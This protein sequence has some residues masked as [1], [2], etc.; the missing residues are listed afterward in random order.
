MPE[1]IGLPVT[2][3]SQV[4]DARRLATNLARNL[5][6]DETRRGRVA[7]IATELATNLVKHAQDGMLVLIP[8]DRAGVG[9]LELIAIDKGP[10]MF[11][12]ARCM[13]DGFSTAGSPGNGL[14]AVDRL[15]DDFDV[16]SKESGT[17][18]L[19]RLWSAA[20]PPGAILN[21]GAVCLPMLGEEVCGDAW[22]TSEHDGRASVLLV[23]GL[24]HGPQAAEAA[25]EAVRVFH[26][27]AGADL[28]EIVHAA[29]AAM[30]STR[31]AVVAVAE[32]DP[33]VQ[34][35]AF[36]GVGN[37]NARVLADGVSQSLISHNG[38]VGHIVRRVQEMTYPWPP[39]SLLVMHSDGISNHWGLDRYGSLSTHD[40]GL[41]AGVL[42]RDFKRERDDSTVVVARSSVGEA[43]R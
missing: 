33:E 28:A 6:F 30:R 29:H 27:L 38:T 34:S 3:S 5:G 35:L 31:G 42:F 7:L 36:V 43:R 4:G 11:D 19:A 25:R 13:T 12:I 24:G 20:I 37:I 17:A 39:G 32:I 15:S 21:I 16:F 9:G 22:A 2:E 1:P 23:D 14:G 40:S 10:G 41:I 8:I 26:D 18:L